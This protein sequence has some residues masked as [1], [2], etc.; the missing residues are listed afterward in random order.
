MADLGAEW[1]KESV[2]RERTHMTDCKLM[3]FKWQNPLL[4]QLIFFLNVEPIPAFSSCWFFRGGT[5]FKFIIF[6]KWTL[7]KLKILFLGPTSL[8]HAVPIH[9]CTTAVSREN[10]E[11]RILIQKWFHLN[12]SVHQINGF[13]RGVIWSSLLR[14]QRLCNKINYWTH[15]LCTH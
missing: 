14:W 2:P 10:I 15:V 7:F 11:I 9:S 4:Q 6:K 3:I 12:V 5:F 1:P 13:K 8:G